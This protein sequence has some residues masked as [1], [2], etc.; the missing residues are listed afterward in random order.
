MSKY[1]LK[2]AGSD[3]S[4]TKLM[5]VPYEDAIKALNKQYPKQNVIK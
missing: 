4:P 2:Y 1:E 5:L 3:L